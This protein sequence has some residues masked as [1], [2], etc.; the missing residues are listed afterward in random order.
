[1]KK[2]IVLI[3]LLTLVSCIDPRVENYCISKGAKP[4]TQDFKDCTDHYSAIKGLH[5]S[6]RYDCEHKA[7][8]YIPMP[9]KT[10]L[11]CQT[12]DGKRE[13]RRDLEGG[14]L[15]RRTDKYADCYTST[16]DDLEAFRST[17]RYHRF[18]YNCLA[19]RGWKNP[20]DFIL[21]K[22]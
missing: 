14:I 10:V 15:I 8:A 18:I 7:K 3:A 4:E 22:K 2:I 11:I 13:R 9:R 12:E 21:G 5:D 19:D 20:D 6:D 1:M 16:E 17:D